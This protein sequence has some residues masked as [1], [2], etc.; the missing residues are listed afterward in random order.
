MK[1]K[2]SGPDRWLEK[3]QEAKRRRTSYRAGQRAAA[4]TGGTVAVPRRMDWKARPE[5]KSADISNITLV[6]GTVAGMGSQIL[7]L[8]VPGSGASQRVGRSIKM[9]S[10]SLNGSFQLND[11][12]PT[13]TAW[14]D[15]VVRWGI[16]YDRQ[17]D[18][19]GTVPVFNEIYQDQASL[20]NAV[21]TTTYSMRN[22]NNKDRFLLL[23]SRLIYVPSLIT[24]NN[25]LGDFLDIQIP[26]S[27]P[28]GCGGWTDPKA[29][30]NPQL[31]QRLKRLNG[32]ET[33]YKAGTNTISDISN[34]S[35]FMFA[36]HSSAVVAV[37]P[38]V[39]KGSVRVRYIDN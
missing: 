24:G 5:I 21:N 36:A 38:I 1:R 31:M 27:Q 8:I 30:W 7:N 32:L 28:S 15:Q 34:G 35:L 17:P 29:N 19:Q 14:H 16:F 3:R 22:E 9:L 33:V 13:N 6:P 10:Y 4:Q 23:E 11:N 2:A 12:A 25:G 26:W 39:W 18:A 20:N 37:C